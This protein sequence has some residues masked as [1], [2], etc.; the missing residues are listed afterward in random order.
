MNTRECIMVVDRDQ[1]AYQ[2]LN[3]TL[4]T[5]G[6]D[7]IVVA[8]SATAL[9]QLHR[10]EPGLIILDSLTNGEETYQELENIRRKSNVPIIVLTSRYKPEDLQKALLLGADD[11][12]HKPFGAKSLIARI[13]AKLR[14][15]RTNAA[16]VS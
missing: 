13:R 7:T 9:S 3:N 12:I 11:Y 14:R 4:E 6:F 10:V 8:D 1:E 5:E 15:Y 2:L 16:L